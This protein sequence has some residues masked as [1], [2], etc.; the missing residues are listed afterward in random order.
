MS[1]SNGKCAGCGKELS[2][3]KYN[4][5]LDLI[6]IKLFMSNIDYRREIDGEMYCRKCSE[7]LIRKK[8]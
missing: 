2:F 7:K 5:L 8:L 3:N 6:S 4:I 1:N